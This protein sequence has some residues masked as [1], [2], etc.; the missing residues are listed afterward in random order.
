MQ[1]LV[2]ILLVILLAVAAAKL[3]L[4]KKEIAGMAKTITRIR[5]GQTNERV[6][7]LTGDKDAAALAS[8]VNTLCDSIHNERA[9]NRQALDEMRMSMANISH[10]LRTPLTSIIGYVKLL[11]DDSNTPEQRRKYLS[12]VADKAS[13]LNRLINSLFVL[14]RLEAGSYGF[15]LER[16]DAATILSEE[17]AGFYEAFTAAGQQ[18]AI[19]L[20]AP[21]WIIGDKS[22]L[23]RVFANLLQNLAKHRAQDIRITGDSKDGKIVL[24]FSNRAKGLSEDDAR[25]LFQRFFTADRMRSGENTGLGLAIVKE[26][27]EQMQ[28]QIS[29]RFENEM[30]TFTLIWPTA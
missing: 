20:A 12:V 21:L 23:A 5:G 6:S 29:C 24:E 16:L 30:L 28:G 4:L 19:E 18:P 2:I 14:A 15:E 9:A 10:D 13:S 11:D 3:L 8:S 7:V 22:A 27:V 17:L 26:F 25:Q 1:M